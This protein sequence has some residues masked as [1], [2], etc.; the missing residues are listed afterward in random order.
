M[1]AHRLLYEPLEYYRD[2]ARNS[3]SFAVALFGFL[4]AAIGEVSNELLAPDRKPIP[5]LVL[6]VGINWLIT[7]FLFGVLW[8]HAG[9]RMLGGRA[10]L[11][12]TLTAVGYA[13]LWPGI[14]GLKLR[15]IDGG[16]GALFMWLASGSGWL[17]KV[18]APACARSSC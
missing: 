16:P 11:E 1:E 3:P 4:L 17:V 18:G 8:F 14:F 2:F 10:P 6:G 7:A 15:S 9:A 13:F 12:V 5:E